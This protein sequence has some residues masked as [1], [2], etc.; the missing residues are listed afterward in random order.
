MNRSP[1]SR[2]LHLRRLVVQTPAK[3]SRKAGFAELGSRSTLAPHNQTGT[4]EGSIDPPQDPPV[5]TEEE[6]PSLDLAFGQVARSYA[7]V[8][9]RLDAVHGRLDSI[10]SVVVTLTLAVP[11]VA[12]AADGDPDFTSAWVIAAIALGG[13]TVV[14]GLWARARSGL[15]LV[16]P[17]HL[18]EN[19]LHLPP[20]EFKKDSLYWAGE[21]FNTN[22]RTVNRAAV[23]ASFMVVLLL[24]EAGLFVA[25]FAST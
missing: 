14:L 22:T 17:A 20:A 5:V 18:Y 21:H 7:E 9:S 4:E 16:N 19:S 15:T 6:Y 3:W 1:L 2:L 24:I 12:L 11:T 23:V 8:A 10:Q 25:W 13:A